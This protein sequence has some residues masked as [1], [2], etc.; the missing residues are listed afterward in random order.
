MLVHIRAQRVHFSS[1]LVLSYDLDRRRYHR[2]RSDKRRS[3]S[4]R[5]RAVPAGIGPAPATDPSSVGPASGR[6]SLRTSSP[7]SRPCSTHHRNVRPPTYPT[8]PRRPMRSPCAPTPVSMSGGV[9]LLE[10]P[11]W[12]LGQIDPK[13][14]KGGVAQARTRSG[15]ANPVVGRAM[16]FVNVAIAT[17]SRLPEVS[18]PPLHAYGC[19]GL[20][21]L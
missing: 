6:P 5:C 21:S 3:R 7:C 1:S 10:T 9:C 16:E 14:E 15:H 19:S 8:S 20:R 2:H 11:K 13:S 4:A 17:H 12:G 18:G